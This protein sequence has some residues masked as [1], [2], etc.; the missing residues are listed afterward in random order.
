MSLKKVGQWKR[1]VFPN[2]LTIEKV[3]GQSHK[4]HKQR[5]GKIID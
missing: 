1:K 2:V 4:N 5:L 3:Q